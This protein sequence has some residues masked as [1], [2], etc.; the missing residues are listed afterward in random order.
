MTE[1]Y[2]IKEENG[3]ALRLMGRAG[4]EYVS[5]DGISYFIDSEM[6]AS[7]EYDFVIFPSSVKRY[8]DYEREQAPENIGYVEVFDD[9]AGVWKGCVEYKKRCDSNISTGEK[10]R[11]IE[12]VKRLCA[13]AGIKIDIT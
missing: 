11:I 13:K 8:E 2:T 6:L 1:D 4:M 7:G 5:P 10:G 9:K 12:R 3:E